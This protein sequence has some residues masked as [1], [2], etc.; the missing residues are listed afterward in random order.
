MLDG[1]DVMLVDL[2]DVGSRFYTFIYTM[3]EVMSACGEAGIPVWVLDRPNPISGRSA[4]GPLVE[5][6][7]ESFVGMYPIPIR[8][9]LTIGELA[10]LFAG[11]RSGGFATP[12]VDASLG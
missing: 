4:E 8:H 1:I 12:P 7:F 10:M 6:G 2:Q 9:A 11:D 5:N 3:A